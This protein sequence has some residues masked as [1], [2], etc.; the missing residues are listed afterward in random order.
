MLARNYSKTN[1]ELDKI[2][3]NLD[4][5]ENLANNLEKE[6][7]LKSEDFK[8]RMENKKITWKHIQFQ[9]LP[10]EAVVEM[11]RIRLNKKG[12]WTDTVYYAALIITEET[13]EHPDIVI[14][15]NGNELENDYFVKYR[16]DIMKKRE[17]A[18]AF[19]QFWQKIYDKTKSYK[20]IYFTP[21]GI[22]NKMNISTFLMPDGEYLIDKQEIHTLNSSKDVLLSVYKKQEG[23]QVFNSA[24]LFGNPDFNLNAESLQM[25]SKSYSE[26]DESISRLDET[27]R[28]V[29]LTSLP[30]TEKEVKN[31]EEFLKSKKWDVKTHIKQEAIKTAVKAVE[32]PR[33][34]SH[35]YS[36]NVS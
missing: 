21:D 6:I 1:K 33:G 13:T 24:E 18:E 5:L 7:S 19:N 34:S 11:V 35:S 27:T 20:K 28:G 30:G 23:S 12:R 29:N 14:L 32:S 4:S 2:G 10:D 25:I 9:L 26:E 31:I 36:W 3:I 15:E 8:T 17:N 16:K 22:Y